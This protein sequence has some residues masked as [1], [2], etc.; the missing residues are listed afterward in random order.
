MTFP[1]KNQVSFW[2]FQSIH[3]IC[4][5]FWYKMAEENKRLFESF[6]EKLMRFI[7]LYKELK[8]ENAS[9]KQSLSE[10]ESE[11]V[12]LGKNLK[13]LESQYANLKMV[14]MLSVNDQEISETKL[15]ITKLVR[16]VDKCIALLNE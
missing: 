6:N 11:I 12:R 8:R 4:L 5:E 9:L 3:Y 14:R 15:R 13:E 7:F 16:E 1:K 2:R 10:K